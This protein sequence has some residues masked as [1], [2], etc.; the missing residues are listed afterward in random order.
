MSVTMAL[1]T[2]LVVVS[3]PS[4]VVVV[5]VPVVIVPV[6]SIVVVPEIGALVVLLSL[7]LVI[8]LASPSLRFSGKIVISIPVNWSASSLWTESGSRLPCGSRVVITEIIW[9]ASI[10][11][12]SI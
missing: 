3:I 8:A 9:P 11:L 1:Y 4:V 5:L 12:S 10:H 2:T 7:L 6:S